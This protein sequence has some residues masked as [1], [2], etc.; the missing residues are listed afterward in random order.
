[1]MVEGGVVN[2]GNLTCV[3]LVLNRDRASGLCG[4][5]NGITDDC[6]TVAIF[7]RRSVGRNIPI[8]D[9][10]AEEM[11]EFMVAVSL[12]GLAAKSNSLV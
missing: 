12:W 2:W 6:V 5:N 7:K 9:N 1:M 3:Q 11:M 10:R 8:V 4:L